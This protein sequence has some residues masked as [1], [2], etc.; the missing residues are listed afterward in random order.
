MKNIKSLLAA[1]AV[2][3]VF[4]ACGNGQNVNEKED[5]DKTM[6]T[7]TPDLAFFDLQ[8]PVKICDMTGFDRSG[9]I[10]FVNDYDPFAVDEPYR[11]FDTVTFDYSD[12][13][14][15]TRDSQGQISTIVCFEG[16]EKF[17]WSEG[18]VKES[19]SYFENQK[20]L[21][22]NEY[23]AEGRLVKQTMYNGM[24]DEDVESKDASTL[25]GTN[26]YK[27]LEFDSHGNWIRRNVKWTDANVDYVDEQEETRRIEYYE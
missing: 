1:C 25:F 12:I 27:Y 5:N 20:T 8:G 3:L 22:V 18:H 10:T 17:T 19:I 21:T 4:G 11:D 2:L 15:W 14:K 9:K 7:S 26:E 13:C 16:I 23:D 24:E 6:V